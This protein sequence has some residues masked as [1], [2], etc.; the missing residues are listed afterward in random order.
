MNNHYNMLTEEILNEIHQLDV[1]KHIVIGTILRKNPK[2]KL[3]ENKNGIMVNIT[4]LPEEVGQEIIQYLDYLKKQECV[5]NK[6]EEE[7]DNM[8][9][10]ITIQE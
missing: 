2:V 10:M 8:K 9:N 5:L 3:N 1:S 7:T 4:T 6:I